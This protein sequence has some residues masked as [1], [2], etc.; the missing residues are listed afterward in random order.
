MTKKN[1]II[2][3]DSY[4]NYV[5]NIGLKAFLQTLPIMPGKNN[6]SCLFP[7]LNYCPLKDSLAENVLF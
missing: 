1:H 7:S 3:K 2:L 6:P 4:K 5:L